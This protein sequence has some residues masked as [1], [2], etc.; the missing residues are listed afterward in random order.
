MRKTFELPKSS[1]HA[2]E[3]FATQQGGNDVNRGNHCD[4]IY[5][6]KRLVGLSGIVNN[7]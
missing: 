5:F 1:S 4:V 3:V 6:C 2:A 7:N